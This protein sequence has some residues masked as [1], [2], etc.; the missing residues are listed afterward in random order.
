MIFHLKSFDF[1][2]GG[3]FEPYIMM[4][5]NSAPFELY[6]ISSKPIWIHGRGEIGGSWTKGTS[7]LMDQTQMVYTTSL[8]W[9]KRGMMYHGF[10][11][12]EIFLGFGVEDLWSAGMDV[13]AEDLL[14]GL[15]LC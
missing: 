4:F 14:E 10:L 8:N 15:L 1:K 9:K 5:K 2:R 6:G 12:D 11:D 7:A 13:V 3:Q